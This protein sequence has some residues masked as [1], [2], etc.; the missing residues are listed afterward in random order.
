MQVEAL[1]PAERALD[2]AAD[3]AGGQ[4]GLALVGGVLLAAERAAVGDEVDED[5]VLGLGQHVGDLAAVVPH[6]LA[7]GEHLQPA[8]VERHDQRRLRLEEGVLDALG[9]EH[10][11]D[12]V[13]AAGEGLVD[14]APGVGAAGQEVPVEA[15]DGV[16]VALE[17]VEGVGE[18]GERV[19]VDVHELGRPAGRGPVVGHDQ[20]ED[21]ARVGRAPAHG[22]E[23]RPVAVDQPHPQLARH[24]GGGDDPDD[25]VD[26]LGLGRVDRQHVGPGV[27][28]QHDGGVQQAGH[29]QVVDVGLVAQRELVGLVLHVA[30]ADAPRRAVG[31]RLGVEAGQGTA[32]SSPAARVSMA[33][34][35]EW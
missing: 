9:L 7:A 29:P 16:L 2:R 8:V 13:G 17:G 30:A 3:Q 33:S 12:G 34:R 25:A 6:A 21:V 1:L 35:I 31:L 5:A 10:L 14:V 24:V 32:T 20:G 26:G 4:R 18:R 23:H 22:D 15:P 19:V 11:V 28:G 27:L